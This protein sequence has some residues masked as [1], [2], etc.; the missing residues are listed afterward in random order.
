MENTKKCAHPSCVCGAA[1]D[2]E[3]CSAFCSGQAET[4]DIVCSCGHKACADTAIA[5]IRSR[6]MS[7]PVYVK[8]AG[9][10]AVGE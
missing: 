7:E 10:T 3:Y 8:G 5:T 6:E 2:S 1:A 4:N 9:V